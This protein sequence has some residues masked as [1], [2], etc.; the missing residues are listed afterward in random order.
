MIVACPLLF[1]FSC[2]WPSLIIVRLIHHGSRVTQAGVDV[3][4]TLIWRCQ[5]VPLSGGNPCIATP[6]QSC[7]WL[8]GARVV[9]HLLWPQF[10][11]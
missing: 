11:V 5:L 2:V 7:G 4:E 8:G 6:P 10:F 9:L 3:H 1:I